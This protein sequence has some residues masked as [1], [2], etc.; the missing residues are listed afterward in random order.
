MALQLKLKNTETIN[1]EG[2]R[3]YLV[4]DTGIFTAT[5]LGGYGTPNT[6]RSDVALLVLGLLKHSKGNQV[7]SFEGYDPKT[8]NKFNAI[9]GQDG[10]YVFS[11]LQLPFL[12]DRALQSNTIG[13]I[14][15]DADFGKIVRVI[16]GIEIGVLALQEVNMLELND[17]VFVKSVVEVFF[18]ANNSKIKLKINT[19][20]SDLIYEEKD[21][22]DK[23]LIRFKDN[24]NAVRALL[25]G[26]IY[27]YCRG[28]KFIAQRDIE[29]LNSN[30]YVSV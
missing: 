23:K 25:Q 1:T 21:F 22:T 12:T 15:Y 18:I 24:Y 11:L 28:N 7:V 5:N 8:T 14:L 6:N 27:E 16:A 19:Q 4:D 2:T 9:I 29:F 3:I 10:W 13:E 26:A 17:S 30:N 20:V